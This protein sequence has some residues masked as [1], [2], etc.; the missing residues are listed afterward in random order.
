MQFKD[1]DHFAEELTKSIQESIEG[2]VEELEKSRNHM[3]TPGSTIHIK[4]ATKGKGYEVHE[5]HENGDVTNHGS[6]GYSKI[7]KRMAQDRE[8]KSV[9]LLRMK[10]SKHK[11][12]PLHHTAEVK[13]VSVTNASTGSRWKEERLHPVGDPHGHGSGEGNV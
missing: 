5:H 13:H 10:D 9:G 12:M 11:G 4:K 7:D 8:G 6:I 3:F 2:R 1:R